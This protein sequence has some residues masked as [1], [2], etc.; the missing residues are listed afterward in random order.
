M[1]VSC[2]K[3]PILT[4]V[5]HFWVSF[6]L[7]EMRLRFLRANFFIDTSC[8]NLC[9]VDSCNTSRFTP[10][11]KNRKKTSKPDYRPTSVLPVISRTFEKLFTDQLYQNL[12]NDGQFF[13]NQSD[14][15]LE[16]TGEWYN[17][18]IFV[19]SLESYSLT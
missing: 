3:S 9:N 10:I 14:F 12:N 19:S 17:G 15:L 16:N 7:R 8:R 1:Q 2:I 18:F 5:R 4:R 11:L 13:N 6:T